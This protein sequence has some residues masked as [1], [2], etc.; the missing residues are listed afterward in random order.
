[1]ANLA[2][3]GTA[4]VVAIVLPPILVRHMDPVSYAVWVLVL[5]IVAY[6]G[7]LD[8][9]LQTAIGRYVAY[10]NENNDLEWRDG[11][12]STAS[13]GLGIAALLGTLLI[14]IAAV[15][16]PSF[17]R[18]IPAASVAPMRMAM[19]IIGISVALGLPASAWNGVFIGLQRY[20]IPAITTGAGRLLS[21][22]GLIF[23]ATRSKSLVWMAIVMAASNLF[24]YALQFGFLRRIASNVRFRIELISKPLARELTGYCL[25]LTVWSFSMLL[26][27]G[28]DVV[29][30]G[31]FQFGAVAAYS[32]S[33][34]LIAFLG[35]VQNS[36]FGV[37]MPYAA[38]LHA[39]QDSKELGDLLTKTTRVGVLLLLITGLPLI[40]FAAPIIKTW[41]GLQY[42]QQG[43]GILVILVVANMLRLTG[44]PYSSILIGTG[45]QKLI[46]V[47]PLM[48]GFTNV[49][50]SIFLGWRY[51][52]IGVAWGTL[53]GAMVGL[54]MNIFYNLPRTRTSINV[55]KFRYAFNALT[56][57]ALCGIPACI[58]MLLANIS[59]PLESVFV[60]PALLVSI[61]LCV[62][63]LLRSSARGFHLDVPS[64]E[65]HP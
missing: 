8:F 35:G 12:F 30:V 58:A 16:S 65:Q 32:I 21:V 38:G 41:I 51:G 57:P 47:S 14:L 62:V 61:V 54:T 18:S 52:A 36:I 7:Y 46:I 3:G 33:A 53:I 2:K 6:V 29:L 22:I 1:V 44:T 43:A 34:T 5:Q 10:A 24:A 39:R 23:V 17:F 13:V 55:G 63:F 48:E 50:S 37:I 15:V 28:F 26:V 11:I 42:V 19:L 45:Q 25:S 4:A 40:V 56:V 49:I 20:E 31:R 9:G 27:T 60:L 64:M 59:K